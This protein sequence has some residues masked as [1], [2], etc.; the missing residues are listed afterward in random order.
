MSQNPLDETCD[1]AST[2]YCRLH[3]YDSLGREVGNEVR[4]GTAANE[5]IYGTQVTYDAIGRVD[6]SRDVL[7][8]KVYEDVGGTPVAINSGTQNLYN[9]YGY[10]YQVNDL[11]SGDML[12]QILTQNARGQVTSEQQGNGVTSQNGYQASTGR[13]LTQHADLVYGLTNVQ[14]IEYQWDVL[15]NLLNRHNTSGDGAN[16]NDLQESFCYDGLNRLIKTAAA[17]LSYDCGTLTVNDQSVQYNSLGNITYKDNVGTYVYGSN[18]GPHAVTSTSD[19]VLFSYD[20]NGNMTG[21]T[22]VGDIGGRNLQY[23]TFDKPNQIV[24]GSHTTEFR[25]GP[26]RKRY[27]RIDQ[28]TSTTTSGGG[29]GGNG[30]GNKKKGGGSGGGTSTSTTTTL[31]LGAV[32]R[33]EE[34]GSNEVKWKRYI[35]GFAVFTLTTQ[36][37]SDGGQLID[38]ITAEEQSYLYKDHLGSL[39]VITDD[40]GTP[41]QGMSFN[42]WGQ[43]RSSVNWV[44]LDPLTSYGFDTTITTRGYTE[45]EMLDEVGLIHM[46]GRIYDPRLG[47]FMQ[48]DPFVQAATDNQML[49]RYSYLRNNPLNATDPSGYFVFTLAAIAYAGLAN[50]VTALVA[51]AVISVGSALDAIAAGG[52]IFDAFRAGMFSFAAVKWTPSVTQ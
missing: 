52:D 25:Y 51:A 49:N 38:V 17:T 6:I 34:S 42:A 23:T 50:G 3:S 4:L 8:G 2:Q 11:K 21:D 46:N 12:R 45:H 47:R 16:Q 44:E 1:A 39:D 36:S 15:G 7:D 26:D 28:S 19:G 22:A 20:A 13:M 9:A 37:Q 41:I 5:G 10:L 48:A 29:G 27:Q 33:I 30:G 32:E 24:K 18:A 14:H 43:R 31:Y 40:V 35:G